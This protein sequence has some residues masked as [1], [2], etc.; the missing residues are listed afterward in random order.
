MSLFDALHALLRNLPFGLDDIDR[1]NASYLLWERNG[2]PADGRVVDLWTY[3]FVWRYLIIKFTKDEGLDE[4]DMDVLLGR[5]Y[6]KITD[7]RTAIRNNDRYASWVSVVCR[8]QFINYLR[9]K[10]PEHVRGLSLE[11]EQVDE[12]D[13]EHNDVLVLYQAL[14]AAIERLPE[15]LRLVTELRVVH[16]R[17]YD[18]ISLLT[19]K[20][21]VVVRS[22]VNKALQRL[23]RDPYFA[24]FCERHYVEEIEKEGMAG[25][26]R[27]S[28]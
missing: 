2:L 28:V 13:D 7:R 18:E 1:I 6:E 20:N 27:V 14:V 8:H 4:V 24:V 3:C 22:Y 23:R 19:G 15:Y 5:I 9:T 11:E 16:D 12:M 17:T 26:D 21:V 10:R 25:E